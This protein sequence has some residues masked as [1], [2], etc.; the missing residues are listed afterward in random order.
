MLS[1]MNEGIDQLEVIY[2]T[3]IEFLV[4]YGFQVVGAIIILVVGLFLAR[5]FGGVVLK[6]CS[7]ANVDVTLTKFF[8]GVVK[9]LVLVFALVIAMAKFGITIAP[10]VAAIGAGASG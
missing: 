1:I 2:N 9:I 4:Q 5:M 7:R 10:M 3:V 8:A 6:I